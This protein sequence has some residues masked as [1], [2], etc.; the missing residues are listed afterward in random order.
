MHSKIYYFYILV[1]VLLVSHSCQQETYE[2]PHIEILTEYGNIEAEL[3]PSRAPLTVAAFLKNVKNK[4]YDKATFYRVLKNEEL[5]EQYNSGLIQGGIYATN[6]EL[7][8]TLPAIAHESPKQTG[9]SHTSGTLSMART[10][11]GTARSEFFICIGDQT[12]FD[13][14]RR[15]NPDGLGYAAFGRVVKGMKIVRKIQA[16]E[17]NG[18]RILYPAQIK[19][20][21]QL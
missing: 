21:I 8:N 13:S 12:Q 7:E 16:L 18:D 17:N 15:T 5:T 14:S 1:F 20:I 10:E 2:N 6:S 11:P 4:V 9:I 19:K 3:F